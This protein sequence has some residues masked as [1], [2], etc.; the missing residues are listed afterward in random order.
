M[1]YKFNTFENLSQLLLHL[2]EALHLLLP[3]MFVCLSLSFA[4][5]VFLHISFPLCF[6]AP[7]L[8]PTPPY[9]LCSVSPVNLLI[10]LLHFQILNSCRISLIKWRLYFILILL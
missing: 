10:S 8:S 6:S 7:S 3:M 5:S 9:T 1:R 4:P 2:N